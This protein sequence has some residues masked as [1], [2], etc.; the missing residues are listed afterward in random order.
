MILVSVHSFN[1]TQWVIIH[2]LCT[3][4]FSKL[5]LPNMDEGTPFKIYIWS[6]ICI[7]NSF[8]QHRYLI[9][10][11][12][13]MVYQIQ[14]FK[15]FLSKSSLPFN[16]C[17]QT[18]CGTDVSPLVTGTVVCIF[19]SNQ[20]FRMPTTWPSFVF[21]RVTSCLPWL[22]MWWICCYLLCMFNAVL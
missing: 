14:H 4:S 17:L 20:S 19:S 16:Q 3:L 5:H 7:I 9:S 10:L 18:L 12:I 1:L 13:I 15:M 6:N 11:I 2:V 21:T 22:A 8:I